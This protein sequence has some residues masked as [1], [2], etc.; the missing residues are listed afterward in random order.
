MNIQ[1]LKMHLNSNGFYKATAVAFTRF[2][3]LREC[4]YLCGAFIR[5]CGGKTPTV[6]V[7]ILKTA[8]KEKGWHKVRLCNG[9]GEVDVFVSGKRVAYSDR[10][11]RETLR[12]LDFG[13]VFWIKVTPVFST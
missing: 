13:L 2:P 11:Q 7:S 6:F 4:N 5:A 9:I 1:N 12:D 8:P 10:N 3:F